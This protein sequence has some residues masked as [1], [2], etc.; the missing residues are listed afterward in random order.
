MVDVEER[1]VTWKFVLFF[2]L[3]CLFASLAADPIS[4][5]LFFLRTSRET[6]LQ[7]WEAVFYW[8]YLP[9]AVYLI[10]IILALILWKL[11]VVSAKDFVYL[12]L[13]FAGVGAILT[14]KTFNFELL[15]TLLLII[16]LA[17]FAFSL[18]YELKED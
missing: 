13:F 11:E 15:S 2:L 5:Y 8:Y 7:H 14:A 6:P 9:A 18:L 3:G 1:R 12:L 16:P 17:V 4:D 10:F